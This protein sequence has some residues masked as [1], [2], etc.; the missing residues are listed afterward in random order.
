MRSIAKL[1]LIIPA[2]LLIMNSASAAFFLRF[3]PTSALVSGGGGGTI[4][5]LA[6]YRDFG[7]GETNSLAS[8]TL[9]LTTTNSNFT[10]STTSLSGNQLNFVHNEE[11]LLATVNFTHTGPGT[12]TTVNF[13]NLTATGSP[14]FFFVPPGSVSLTAV[15]EPSSFA[16]LGVAGIGYV[17][18]RRR[19]S[20]SK[21]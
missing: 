3:N 5:V 10:L 2:F 12:T 1:A 13:G 20:A 9:P 6:R 8:Y 21:P 7:D 11:R 16:L 18:Y 19:R 17:V 15:P 4:N 14:S